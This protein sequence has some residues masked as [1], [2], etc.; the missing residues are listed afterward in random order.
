MENISLYRKYRPQTFNDVVG[1]DNIIKTL[2][3]AITNKHIA[4]AYIFN[5]PRGTGKTS[6]AKIFAKK[7]SCTCSDNSCLAC[8][9]DN[10]IDIWEIDAASNNGVEEVGI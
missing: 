7:I 1:Q 6:I 5:G 3:N 8:T 10:F 2:E 4:H 9:G